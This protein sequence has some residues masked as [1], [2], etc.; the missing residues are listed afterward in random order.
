MMK[1]AAE[2]MVL[3]FIIEHFFGLFQSMYIGL[4]QLPYNCIILGFCI[5]SRSLGF[6]NYD[7][8][9]DPYIALPCCN[10]NWW[11]GHLFPGYF[12]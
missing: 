4:S 2:S 5:R 6:D 7:Q 3:G 8:S 9:V 1:P 12:C 10:L 11:K